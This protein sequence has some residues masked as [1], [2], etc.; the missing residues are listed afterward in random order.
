[1]KSSVTLILSADVRFETRTSFLVADIRCFIFS[2]KPASG[3]QDDNS[4]FSAT[5]VVKHLR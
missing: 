1:M 3:A 4:G 5:F 2:R